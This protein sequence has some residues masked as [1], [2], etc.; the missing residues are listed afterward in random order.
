MRPMMRKSSSS[1]ST[2]GPASWRAR[3]RRL[4]ERPCLA[5]A[6]RAG[7]RSG[8]I[9][10]E[11]GVGGIERASGVVSPQVKKAPAAVLVGEDGRRDVGDLVPAEHLTPDQ[12]GG[13]VPA[14]RCGQQ[15]GGRAIAGAA[16]SSG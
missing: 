5:L 1:V 3:G 9:G 10:E 6:Q 4:D 15:P 7:Q 12:A 11:R 16:R 8:D 2:T 14:S 13:Q